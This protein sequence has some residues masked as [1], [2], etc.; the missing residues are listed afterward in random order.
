MNDPDCRVGV[1]SF[2]AGLVLLPLLA[3]C[4]GLVLFHKTRAYGGGALWLFS[5]LVGLSTWLLGA[6]FTFGS[7]GSFGWI[8]LIVG[9]LLFGIGVVPLGAFGAVWRSI[10]ASGIS[11]RSSMSGETL[12]ADPRYFRDAR[13]QRFD[14]VRRGVFG[15][16]GAGFGHPCVVVRLFCV[17]PFE[18][19]PRAEPRLPGRVR[20]LAVARLEDH[21][22][23]GGHNTMLRQKSVTPALG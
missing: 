13:G 11:H 19:L 5:W 14:G 1:S 17:P 10:S 4:G 8:G 21:N 15:G 7:F 3:V 9:L 6:A 20:A 18:S 12:H 2:D 16:A 23:R 22:I